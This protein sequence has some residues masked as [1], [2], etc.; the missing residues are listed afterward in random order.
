MKKL[1]L[2]ENLVLAL[3]SEILE[4]RSMDCVE[5]SCGGC[6]VA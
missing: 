5:L 6:R 4:E 1:W 3:N 2:V